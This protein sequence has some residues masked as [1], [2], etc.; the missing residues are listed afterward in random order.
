MSESKQ[1]T[2]QLIS[3]EQ[4]INICQTRRFGLAV[5][6]EIQ[7]RLEQ[8]VE[9][10]L[11][12]NTK[13][14]QFVYQPTEGYFLS[15]NITNDDNIVIRSDAYSDVYSEVHGVEKV[16]ERAFVSGPQSMMFRANMLKMVREQLGPLA[17]K[18]N[19]K[20]LVWI[21]VG[22]LRLHLLDDGSFNMYNPEDKN[23]TAKEVI[24]V[25][26]KALEDCTLP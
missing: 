20:D 19:P 7:K 13:F 8:P 22:S 21:R 24:P 10:L 9:I 1:N 25:I 6:K 11:D 14:V 18:F 5:I 26:K 17:E 3:L 4:A 15:I 2:F 23:F 16:I 12:T